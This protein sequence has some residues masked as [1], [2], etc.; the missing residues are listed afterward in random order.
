MQNFG[1]FKNNIINVLSNLAKSIKN[2][3]INII[4]YLLKNTRNVLIWAFLTALSIGGVTYIVN[5][6]IDYEIN[7]MTE[8]RN[9][10]VNKRSLKIH[11][12]ECHS[13]SRM[14]ERNKLQINNS[15]ENLLKQE[16]KEKTNLSQVH[17]KTLKIYYL[18]VKTLHLKHMMNT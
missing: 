10:I 6:P 4:N 2:G 9:Y 3:V 16:L 17:L 11:I 14:S 18:E 7:L 5:I 15:L 8:Y 1:K 13:V 12:E